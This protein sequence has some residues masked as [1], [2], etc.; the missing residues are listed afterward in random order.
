MSR[1]TVQ[2][3]DRGGVWGEFDGPTFDEAVTNAL[4]DIARNG[5]RRCA[6][7][8]SGPECDV[9]FDGLTD[10]ERERIPSSVTDY[11]DGLVCARCLRII[12]DTAPGYERVCEACIDVLAEAAPTLMEG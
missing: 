4:R 2:V 3:G 10:D 1:Y 5:H 8:V 9:D 11:M 12:D 6:L 7:A